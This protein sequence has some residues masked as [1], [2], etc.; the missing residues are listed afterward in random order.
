MWALVLTICSASAS[1]PR[2]ACL[3]PSA[4]RNRV[5]V[6]KPILAI[7]RTS[8]SFPANT[9]SA[10]GSILPTSRL[11][12][13]MT[14]PGLPSSNLISTVRARRRGMGWSFFRTAGTTS[15]P[16]P[17]AM[18]NEVQPS[19]A[20]NKIQISS[21]HPMKPS[22]ARI[23]QAVRARWSASLILIAVLVHAALA[24]D[25]ALTL[26]QVLERADQQNPELVAARARRAIALAGV[27]IAK[28]RPNPTVS[29]SVSRDAPH[30]SA[31]MEQPLELGLKRSERIQLAEQEGKVIDVGIATLSR[32]IRRRAREG[33]YKVLATRA[34][35]EQLASALELARR[36][37]DIAQSR[38]ELGDVAQLEVLQAQLELSRAETEYK[39]A[40]QQAN[41]AVTGL[42]VL[43]NQSSATPLTLQGTISELPK[44]PELKELTAKTAE[45]NS[46]LQRLTQERNVELRRR[47]LLQWE[48]VPNLGVQFG[49]DLNS[50]PDFDVG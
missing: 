15:S 34:Q 14:P 39:L 6:R 17:C 8:T 48:R 25:S 4:A 22:R 31:L 33:F 29:F 44:T 7:F 45:S 26:Q 23:L 10:S 28:Q 18:L 11:I 19:Q 36:L 30:E 12:S 38:F 13:L 47:S 37:R 40:A 49:T 32:Q 2:T 5:W 27:Q 43:L 16:P 1:S 50:P 35:A 42:N 20:S 9:A 46:E 41:I 24:Q 21:L 3:S